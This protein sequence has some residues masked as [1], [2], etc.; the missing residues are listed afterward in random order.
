ML[1][2]ITNRELDKLGLKAKLSQRKR[3]NYNFHKYAGDPMQ[4]M[5]HAMQPGTYVQPHKHENPDK[6]EIFIILTGRIAVV[7][8]DNAGNAIKHIVLDPE[9]GNFGVEIPPRTWH[10]IIALQENS[11]VY[12]VKDGPYSP[13]DDKNFAAWAPHEGD[14]ACYEFVQ[15]LSKKLNLE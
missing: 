14:D 5:L 8:Y 13:T 10:S 9:K 15:N 6:R 2:K 11:V 3:M 1:I 12:E 7:E 4:R